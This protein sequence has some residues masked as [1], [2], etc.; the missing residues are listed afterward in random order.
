MSVTPPEVAAADQIVERVLAGMV[1]R[2]CQLGHGVGPCTEDHYD[3]LK[4][5]VRRIVIDALATV[6]AEGADV[7]L[8]RDELLAERYEAIEALTQHKAL[9][10]RVTALEAALRELLALVEDGRLVRN[11][12]N[13]AHMPSYLS[14]S[15]RL[16]KALATAKEALAP[17]AGGTA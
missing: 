8:E 13:D 5:D 9:R 7:V 15:V 10:A 17:G 4:S 12:T 6:R 2:H 11:T 1:A 3:L 14:E 16:V